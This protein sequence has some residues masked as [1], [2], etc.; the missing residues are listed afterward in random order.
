MMGYRRSLQPSPEQG[1]HT[2][3]K[4]PVGKAQLLA[5]LPVPNAPQSPVRGRLVG[6]LRARSESESSP[7]LISGLVH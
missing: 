2:L 3:V 5:C 7:A 6:V 4:P 1:G